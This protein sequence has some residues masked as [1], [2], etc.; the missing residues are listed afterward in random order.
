MDRLGRS[1]PP[2]YPWVRERIESLEARA[3]ELEAENARLTEVGGRH[4][5]RAESLERLVQDMHAE[6]AARFL[7]CEPTDAFKLTQFELR[8]K[9]LH[10]ERRDRDGKD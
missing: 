2:E 4:M 6:M 8:M 1:Y 3:R 9:R 10:V 7:K 5:A